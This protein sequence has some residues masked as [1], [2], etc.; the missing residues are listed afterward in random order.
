MNTSLT[1]SLEEDFTLQ[2]TKTI[3]EWFFMGGNKNEIDIFPM[4]F[5]IIWKSNSTRARVSI[6]LCYDNVGF[7]QGSVN[8][9]INVIN[10]KRTLPVSPREEKRLRSL[11]I[12]YAPQSDQQDDGSVLFSSTRRPYGGAFFRI[13]APCRSLSVYRRARVKV[14][15]KALMLAVH[16]PFNVNGRPKYFFFFFFFILHSI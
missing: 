14:R 10:A 12:W 2:L 3:R 13:C 9:L 7:R 4:F 15:R 5:R 1:Y 16:R 8:Q 11:A 6:Y